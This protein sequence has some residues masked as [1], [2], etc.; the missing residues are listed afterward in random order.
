MKLNSTSQ[1]IR[2]RF[3]RFFSERNHVW[4]ALDVRG[5]R[6]AGAFESTSS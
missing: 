2:H 4:L 5:E 3:Q 6:I 1:V